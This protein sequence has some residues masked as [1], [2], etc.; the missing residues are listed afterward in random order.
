MTSL[1]VWSLFLPHITEHGEFFS[2]F[3]PTQSEIK[4]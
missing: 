3:Y 2:D 4:F 1:M